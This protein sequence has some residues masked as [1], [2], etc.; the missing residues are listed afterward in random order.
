[1][2]PLA[3]RA[4]VRDYPNVHQCSGISFTFV[5]VKEADMEAAGKRGLGLYI[6]L[7]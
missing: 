5:K 7:F 2:H 3:A 4:R 1:V 6:G